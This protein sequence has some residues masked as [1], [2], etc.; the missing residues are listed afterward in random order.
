[1]SAPTVPLDTPRPTGD[2][3]LPSPPRLFTPR[4]G[5]VCIWVAAALIAFVWLLPMLW[6][7]ATSVKPEAETTAYPPEWTA[8]RFTGEAYRQVLSQ[9]DLVVWF[10]NSTIVAVAVTVITV[11]TSAWAAYA[12]ARLPF[13]G[14]NALYALTIAGI[15]VPANVLVVPLFQQMRIMGMVDT[16]WGIILPQVVAPAMVFILKKFFE[17]VPREL[18][19]AAQMDGAG[20]GR[21]FWMIVM[22]LCRP[23]LAA[24]S[25]FVFIGAWNNFFWP[26]IVTSDPDLMT[27]PVGL[28]NVQNAFGV[29]YAQLM[30]AAVL[31]ALP[32]VLIFLFFQ[33]QIVRGVATAGLGGN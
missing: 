23:I 21:I 24:V 22:P 13:R 11:I 4:L 31:A 15:I 18:E 26:F 7:L 32:L 25:I 17:A 9:G 27:L 30:A 10:L 20:R 28:A 33:R 2:G 1:M 29:R 6:A 19:D 3:R 12:F 14:R 8:S 5:R 16:Y